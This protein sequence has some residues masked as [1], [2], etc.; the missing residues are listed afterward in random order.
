MF[1]ESAILMPIQGRA[2]FM[3]TLRVAKTSDVV[4]GLRRPAAGRLLMKSAVTIVQVSLLT[5]ILGVLT[6]AQSPRRFAVS[7]DGYW[8]FELD[9]TDAG[10]RHG[11]DQGGRRG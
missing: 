1:D 8:N 6:V 5:T 7:L 10:L 9:P 2:K 3:A 4:A 11:V